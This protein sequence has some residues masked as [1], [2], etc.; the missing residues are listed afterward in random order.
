MKNK[1]CTYEIALKL[2]ELGFNDECLGFYDSTIEF[3]YFNDGLDDG[4]TEEDYSKNSD[5]IKPYIAAPL[6]Q[7]VIDWFRE[8]YNIHV[9]ILPFR[10]YESNILNIVYYYSIVDGNETEGD[11]LCNENDLCAYG[12]NYDTYEECREQ[13]ILK[14]IELC[15][16]KK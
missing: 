11:I 1:F 9:A 10:E 16:N 4:S 14:A 7:D 13:V 2:K 15:Q 6:W 5:L 3:F 8:K 12:D